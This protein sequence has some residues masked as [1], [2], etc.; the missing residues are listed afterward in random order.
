MIA[1]EC[2]GQRE[3]VFEFSITLKSAVEGVRGVEDFPPRKLCNKCATYIAQVVSE[4]PQLVAI[5]GLIDAALN[6]SPKPSKKEAM[7]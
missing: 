2:C 5:Q 7:Q 6:K 3:F 1:C 4:M